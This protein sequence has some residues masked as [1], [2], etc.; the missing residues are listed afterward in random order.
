MPNIVLPIEDI[1]DSIERPVIFDIIRQVMEIT[2]ISHETKINFLG[3]EGKA[4]QKNSTITKDLLTENTWNYDERVTIEVDEDYSRDRLINTYIQQPET[5]FI[6]EDKD[7]PVFIKPVYSKSEVKITIKYKTRD[8]NQANRWRNDI[9][10]RTAMMRDINLHEINYHYHLQEEFIY[11]LKEIHRL[12]ENVAGY[13]DEWDDYFID[14][15]TNKASVVTNVSGQ[16]A[17]WAVSE[18]QIRVQGYFDF[19]GAPEKGDKEGEHDNWGMGVVYTFNYDKPIECN[20]YYPL[21]IHNQLVSDK[22]RDTVMPYKLENQNRAY[23]LSG[24]AFAEFESDNVVLSTYSN[25]GICI[26]S[27][28][29]FMPNFVLPSTIRVFTALSSITENDRKSLFNLHDLGDFSLSPVILD[30][31]TKSEYPYLGK[32]YQS[33]FSLS[34]Y[35]ETALASDGNLVVD[36]NLN[37]SSVNDLALRKSHRVR[38]GLVTDMTSLT[39]DALSRIRA[40][41]AVAK[42]LIDAINAGISNRGGQSDIGKNRLSVAD[43]VMLT[44]SMDYANIAD[45][46][47]IPG[48]NSSS[49]ARSGYR[50]SNGDFI[51]VDP[52]SARRNTPAYQDSNITGTGASTY[53]GMGTN[54]GDNIVYMN[55]KNGRGDRMSL[56]QTLFVSSKQN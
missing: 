34:L 56:V 10:T 27:F 39:M 35:R 24:R 29:D 3:D 1:Q 44:G 28:D 49:V 36:S 21:M 50:D 15:L 32:D 23:T 19:E 9:R 40:N 42:V 20:M 52:F 53:K 16:Q 33:I 6:F 5:A 18:K 7:L 11:I 8:K 55:L 13:G 2:R 43:I 12:R 45:S 41:P 46:I 37:V 14:R 26:P 38:L 51:P 31:L 47:D 22:F 25:D 4:A 48:A 30:F 54:Y 17:I